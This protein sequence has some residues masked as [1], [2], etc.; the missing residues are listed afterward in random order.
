VRALQPGLS[1]ARRDAVIDAILS[2]LRERPPALVARVLSKMVRP[3]DTAAIR[4]LAAAEAASPGLAELLDVALRKAVE[5]ALET[6][7]DAADPETARSLLT[8]FA[9]RADRPSER[10]RVLG[11]LERHVRSPSRRISLHAHRLLRTLAPRER[12]LRA[13]RALL[14]DSDPT[15]IRLAIRV[16]AFGGDVQSAGAL[17]DRLFH[18]HSGVSR[19]AREGLLALGEAAVSELLRSRGKMRPDRRA[20]IDAVLAEIQSSAR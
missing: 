11:I 3:S 18:P 13:T 2:A 6:T 16:L 14:D 5:R 4:A 17:A 15:T 20:A 7:L 1:R 12:Y 10:E 19:A 9:N 8:Y